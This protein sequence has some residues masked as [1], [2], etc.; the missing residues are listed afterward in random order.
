MTNNFSKLEQLTE[1]EVIKIVLED[2]PELR[3]IWE[4]RHLLKSPAE[5]NEVNP[6]FHILIE[7]IVENQIIKKDPPE[8]ER[9]LRRLMENGISH[10][11]ARTAI[12]VIFINHLFETLKEQI[13]FDTEN[14]SKQLSMLGRKIEK[15]GRNE[16]CPCGSGKKFKYCCID[17]F[18]NVPSLE[19]RTDFQNMV[20]EKLILGSGHY[21]TLGYLKNAAKD[22]PVLILENRCHISSFLEEN[23]D[24]EGG[25]MVLKENIALA[26]RLGK[27]ALITNAY[28]DLLLFCQNNELSEEGIEF[29]DKFLPLSS[30]ENM[31]GYLLCDKADFLASQGKVYEAE[32]EYESIFK[33]MP[34]WYFGRYRYALFLENIGRKNEAIEVL[35][36]LKSMGQKLDKDTYDA[37][38]DVLKYI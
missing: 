15:V 5:I 10:H 14:Y 29:I 35:K 25:Y 13:P 3:F 7:S 38:V 27:E 32:R 11:G 36:Q 6:I 19:G 30:E 26:E 34:E 33:D 20:D 4:R 17:K 2:H 31:T 1:D 18:N 9:T 28:H 21:A 16:L 37:V 22:D 8:V 12:A 23:G 24:I